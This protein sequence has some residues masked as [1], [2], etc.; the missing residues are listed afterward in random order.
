[1]GAL[2]SPKCA[3]GHLMKEPNLYW[4]KNGQRECKACKKKRNLAAR[5]AG[6]RPVTKPKR[7]YAPHRKEKKAL[8]TKAE[9]KARIRATFGGAISDDL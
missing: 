4:R 9:L 3:N 5:L 1:M 7:V 2:K 8:T 6:A